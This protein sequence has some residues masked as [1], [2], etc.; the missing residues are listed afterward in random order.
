MPRHT[1][2]WRPTRRRGFTLVELLV[3][4]GIIAL[5]LSGRALPQVIRS[6]GQTHSEFRRHLTSWRNDLHD[7]I[8]AAPDAPRDQLGDLRA[9]IEN[10]NPL[11]VGIGHR[12]ALNFATSAPGHAIRIIKTAGND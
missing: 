12:P 1:F 4:I 8:Y 5:L 10:Q 6:W 9:E 3:V 2:L 7:A 11:G